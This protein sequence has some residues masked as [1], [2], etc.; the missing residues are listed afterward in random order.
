[1]AER[2]ALI[3]GI[4][5]QDGSYLAELLLEKGYEVF[6][7]TRRAST[8]NGAGAYGEAAESVSELQDVPFPSGAAKA[9]RRDFFEELG[10]FAEKLSSTERTSSSAGGWGCAGYGSSSIRGRRAPRL[11]RRPQPAE[12]ILAGP[13]PEPGSDPVPSPARA[14][15]PRV[16]RYSGIVKKAR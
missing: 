12:A 16:A 15:N 1:V 7:M 9:I 10:G 13:L 11:R 5:G 2:R 6:G 14:V 3:T 4:T 8:E